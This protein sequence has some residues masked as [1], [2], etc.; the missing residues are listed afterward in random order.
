M[1]TKKSSA[2]SSVSIMIVTLLAIIVFMA[3]MLLQLSASKAISVK[4][5]IVHVCDAYLEQ[6][7]SDGYLTDEKMESLEEELKALGCYN[8]NFDGTDIDESVG[9]S[10]KVNLKVTYSLNLDLLAFSSLTESGISIT[11]VTDVYERYTTCYN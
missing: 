1:L 10:N 11:T 6:M 5:D 8:I 7:M 9:Y 2:D 4:N 3:M